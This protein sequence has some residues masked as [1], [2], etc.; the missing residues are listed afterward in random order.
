MNMHHGL[1]END[2]S[3]TRKQLIQNLYLSMIQFTNH[4]S[5]EKYYFDI[6]VFFK[7]NM[8]HK[9]AF[10]VILDILGYNY[11]EYLSNYDNI[12]LE[13]KKLLIQIYFKL[14]K[15]RID[16]YISQ[17]SNLLCEEQINYILSIIT[18]LFSND[19]LNRYKHL[20]Y[21]DH[22]QLLK[23][24]IDKL[25]EYKHI[26]YSVKYAFLYDLMEAIGN[27]NRCYNKLIKILSMNNDDFEKNEKHYYHVM[28][29]LK[30]N[31]YNCITY[32]QKEKLIDLFKEKHSFKCR[33]LFNFYAVYYRKRK[34]ILKRFIEYI[35]SMVDIYTRKDV[36]TD[37]HQKNL[38]VNI[39]YAI[40]YNKTSLKQSF[41]REI[42]AM[43]VNIYTHHVNIISEY[44]FMKLIYYYFANNSNIMK[45]LSNIVGVHMQDRILQEKINH[46]IY[47]IIDSF[48]IL[49]SKDKRKIRNMLSITI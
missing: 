32:E 8:C 20:I 17:I 6:F 40:L 30:N 19:Y 35:H 13:I 26:N 25:F 1:I 4:E 29:I 11:N 47:N 9:T 36:L 41:T 44:Y 23:D 34:E 37:N 12:N 31:D 39:K 38:Y 10:K 27:K 48:F 42:N 24:T 45:F 46:K 22:K 43:I 7:Q 21:D 33:S 3:Q 14:F 2:S 15:K 18:S 16:N 28:F 49:T 5:V